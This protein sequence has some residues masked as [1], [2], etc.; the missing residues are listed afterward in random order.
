[1]TA[2]NLAL[3][4]WLSQQHSMMRSLFRPDFRV[5]GVKHASN[6]STGGTAGIC[7]FRKF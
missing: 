5:E 3:T 4:F 7:E 2:K 1:M 6:R